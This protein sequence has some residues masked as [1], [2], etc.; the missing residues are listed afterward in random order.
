MTRQPE[1]GS[2]HL[3][4]VRGEQRMSFTDSK[5]YWRVLFDDGLF[6]TAIPS[7]GGEMCA[8][9]YKR[10]RPVRWDGTCFASRNDTGVTDEPQRA[11]A[12]VVR[13]LQQEIKMRHNR[14]SGLTLRTCDAVSDATYTVDVWN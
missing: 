8:Y 2:L 1:P 11:C 6:M 3:G 9:A 12:N 7:P 14:A 13:V 4:T 10:S 5:E